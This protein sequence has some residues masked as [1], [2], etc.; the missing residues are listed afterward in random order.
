MTVLFMLGV[1]FG[2][3]SFLK[4]ILETVFFFFNLKNYLFW[5]RRVLAAARGIFVA[6]CRLLSSCGTRAQ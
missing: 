3:L 6:A 2:T 5:L 1:L 4:L